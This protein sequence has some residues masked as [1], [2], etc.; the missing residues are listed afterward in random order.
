MNTTARAA[1]PCV[2]ALLLFAC[3]DDPAQAP[4]PLD[5]GILATFSVEGETFRVWTDVDATI[6]DILALQAGQS[7]ATIPNGTLVRGAGPGDFNAPYSWHIDPTD[8]QMAELTIEVCSGTPSYVEANVDE[9][10]DVVG[11]YCPW[12]AELVAVEDHR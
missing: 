11:Q 6:A 8:L 12:S 4:D 1:V 10:V 9:W 5:G 2:A 7:S 3:S